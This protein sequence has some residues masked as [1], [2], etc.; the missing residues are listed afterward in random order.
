M[1]EK[2]ILEFAIKGIEAEIEKHEKQ[3]RKG[4][5]Y[6]TDLRNGKSIKSPKSESEIVEIIRKNREEAEILSK[7]KF[8]LSWKLDVELDK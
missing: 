8:D 4:E 1:N 7:K 6:L 5:Q 3:I 2:E